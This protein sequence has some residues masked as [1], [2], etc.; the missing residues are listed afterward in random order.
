MMEGHGDLHQ[1][2]KKLLL[3]GGR[4]VPD[5]FERLMRLKKLGLVEQL[6]A[7]R[8]FFKIHGSF[9]HRII[10]SKKSLAP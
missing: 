5:I 4:A 7:A 6:N 8:E 10:R 2:L 3:R 9:G 1:P